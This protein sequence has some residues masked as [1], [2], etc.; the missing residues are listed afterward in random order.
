M[1]S[2]S[3]KAD[4]V[5]KNNGSSC[6]TQYISDSKQSNC[7]H[8]KK[9]EFRLFFL[10]VSQ[11]LEKKAQTAFAD[12][13]IPVQYCSYAKGTASGEF[14]DML[15]LGGIN[16]SVMISILPKSFSDKFLIKVENKLYLGT[17]N[18]GVAFTIPISKGS[19]ALLPLTDSLE[20]SNNT[21]NKTEGETMDNKYT[22]I[23]AFVDQGFSEE[24]MAAARPQGAAGGSVFHSRR[25]GNEEAFKLWG[26][27]IQ[28]E[29]EIVM[30]LAKKESSSDIMKAITE[31]CGVQSDAHGIVIS[32]PVDNAVGLNYDYE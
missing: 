4:N 14:A 21:T 23:M 28:E 7:I 32:M 16:K 26:I 29:R 1:T 8:N 2:D 25:L 20:D 30:I 11:K 10:I 24:V 22:M 5:R 17:P 9:P 18:T 15:G 31:K 13:K 19:A 3:K 12:C 27:K 6:E